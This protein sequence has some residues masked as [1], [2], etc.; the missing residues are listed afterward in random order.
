MQL[1]MKSRCERC[2]KNLL[3]TQEAFICS[4]ECT[5]CSS[6]AAH[7]KGSCSHCGG[8]LV[9]RPRRVVPSLDQEIRETEPLTSERRWLIWLVSF[10]VWAVI[11]VLGTVTITGFYRSNG[12]GIGFVDTLGLECSQILPYPPL[13]P[14]VFAFAT[15]YPI[16][17]HNW[18]RQPILYLLGVQLFSL[19]PVNLREITHY[20]YS[21]P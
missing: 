18:I 2:G 12:R 20:G 13:T 3:P 21:V 10:G 4:Y 9:R 1:E 19:P 14:F 5:F 8:E 16:P 6:C 17:R 15:R 11:A 7:A